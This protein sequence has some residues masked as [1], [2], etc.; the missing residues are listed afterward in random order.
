VIETILD[1]ISQ[2]VDSIRIDLRAKISVGILYP[3]VSYVLKESSKQAHKRIDKLE[4]K[5][6]I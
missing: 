5:G 4:E 6:E 2:S 3:I 1:N